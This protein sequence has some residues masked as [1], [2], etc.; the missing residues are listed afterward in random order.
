MTNKNFNITDE[1]GKLLLRLSNERQY[2]N[3]GFTAFIDIESKEIQNAY[4]PLEIIRFFLGA[5]GINVFLLANLINPG[6]EPLDPEIPLIY[7]SGLLSGIVPSGARGNLTGWSPESKILLDSNGGDEFSSF[8]KIAG[9]DHL[10]LYKKSEKPVILVIEDGV[11]SF[12]PAEM[13]QGID[14][15]EFRSI[16]E[17]AFKG[18]FG[19]DLAMLNITSTGENG[20][21]TSGVMAG[22][23]AIHARGGAGAKMSSLNIKAILIINRSKR[24]LNRANQKGVTETNRTITR[25]V[26]DTEVYRVL[27]KVGTPFLYKVSR[28]LW[29]VG[30][31]NNSETVFSHKLDAENYDQYRTGMAGCYRCPVRCRPL[32]DIGNKQNESPII[33]MIKVADEMGF[34]GRSYLKGDG[35]EYVT[36]GKFGSNIGIDDPAVVIFL[37]N[38]CNDLGLDTSGTGG[39]IAWAFECFEKG[40]ITEKDTGFSL[41]W[42]DALAAARCLFLISLNEGFGKVLIS[43]S[44][45]VEE[46]FYP[47]EALK[48]RMTIKGLMQSDPHDAR[49]LKAFALGLATSTRG[50]DHL[51]NRPTLEINARINDD[52]KF[53]KTLYGGEVSGDPTSYDGKE[54]AVKMCEE[55]YAVGDSLGICRFTTKLFNSPSLPDYKL[56]AD[57]IVNACGFEITAEELSKV[58]VNIRN[59][60]R[61]INYLFGM[62]KVNDTVPDRWMKEAVTGGPYKGELIDK[63]KFSQLISRYYELCKLNSEGL[64][65]AEVRSKL[66][67][68]VY[69]YNIDVIIHASAAD[70]LI[71]KHVTLNKHIN[72]L[73]DLY[74]ELNHIYPDLGDELK[75]PFINM[76]INGELILHGLESVKFSDGDRIEFLSAMG[77]G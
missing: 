26:M 3:Q 14:N 51:R 28:K 74:D 19:R 77:G 49:I 21:L 11:I 41:K 22:I 48:Y 69:G 66:N 45:A 5:R 62:R 10:V 60:E 12:K 75:K 20:A 53:K 39:A 73:N 46:G 63:N 71:E 76:S 68:I 38:I 43:G 42:G 52:P 15:L 55:I 56:W 36:V 59:L 44:R 30:T 6:L 70:K 9:F 65:K 37:N 61:L 64:P 16:I 33:D 13:W 8:L 47:E 35:P 7:G 32:M 58:G 29:A 31:K 23:K 50:S 17:E 2:N 1:V 72:S 57:Q 4:V 54:Y 24:K 18:K 40:L 34:H 27:S 25:E 67:K